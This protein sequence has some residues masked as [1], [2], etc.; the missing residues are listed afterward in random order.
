[1]PHVWKTTRSID[2]ENYTFSNRCLNRESKA[3]STT[4]IRNDYDLNEEYKDLNDQKCAKTV[5]E[6]LQ[7]GHDKQA[8]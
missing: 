6:N 3:A 2:P 5:L 4:T 1:M 7:Q 8:A